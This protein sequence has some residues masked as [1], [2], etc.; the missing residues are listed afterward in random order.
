MRFPRL[1]MPAPVR[2][3]LTGVDGVTYAPSR[4]Y[5]CLG[6]LTMIVLSVWHVAVLGKDFSATDFGTGMS[7]IL[8]AG[9]LGV[10]MTQKTEPQGT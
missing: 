4:V 2:H 9:G 5:W 3:V 1:S 10:W 8:A 6:A 7:S